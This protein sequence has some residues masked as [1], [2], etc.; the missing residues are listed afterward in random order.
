VLVIFDVPEPNAASAMTGDVIASGA[1][2]NVN[3]TR[4]WT[5]DEVTQVRQKA[6]Q[7]KSSYTPPGG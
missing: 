1:V 4:L 3:L 6:A 5:P 2:H 7:I